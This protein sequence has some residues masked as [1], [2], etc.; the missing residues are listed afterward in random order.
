MWRG[1]RYRLLLNVI[2]CLGR[3]THYGEAIALD[4]SLVDREQARAPAGRPRMREW[5]PEVELLAAIYDRLS[6]LIQIQSEKSLNLKPWPSPMT[7]AERV[8]AILARRQY[9]HLSAKL[10]PGRGGAR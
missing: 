6:A 9:D 2:D 1:R 10:F 4:E 5:S 7:A 8:N 3:D